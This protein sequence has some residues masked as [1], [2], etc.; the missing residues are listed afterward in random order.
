MGGSINKTGADGDLLVGKF[1][2]RSNVE[3]GRGVVEGIG[4]SFL[5]RMNTGYR[6]RFRQISII[7]T[8]FPFC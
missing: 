6:E 1:G 7:C 4:R 5:P 2:R 3:S 8:F